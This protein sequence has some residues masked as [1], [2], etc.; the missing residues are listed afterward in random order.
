VPVLLEEDLTERDDGK[1]VFFF[2]FNHNKKSPEESYNDVSE[3]LK[4]LD[5]PVVVLP[6]KLDS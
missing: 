4:G 2:P 5:F 6:L 1:T 3:K